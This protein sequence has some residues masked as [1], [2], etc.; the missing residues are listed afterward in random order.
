MIRDWAHKEE[1]KYGFD[2][3]NKYLKE[4]VFKMKPQHM[5]NMKKLRRYIKSS[6][7]SI[8]CFLMPHPGQDAVGKIGF[9]GS[10]SSLDEE[11]V[12][13]L[14]V[15]VPGI[16]SPE[17]L[18]L[19]KI[20]GVE[21]TGESLYWEILFYI[22]LL[23]S[24]KIPSAQSIYESTVSKFLQDLVSK[25]AK[26]YESTI[27]Q[28]VNKI[29]TSQELEI[30]HLNSKKRAMDNY[31]KEKKMGDEDFIT[32]YSNSLIDIIGDM[33]EQ[34]SKSLGLKIKNHMIQIELESARN[35]T[36]RQ[37]QQTEIAAKAHEIVE[38]R[39]QEVGKR[40]LEEN[41]EIEKKDLEISSLQELLRQH[42]NDL[43][44]MKKIY[45][46]RESEMRAQIEIER[47]KQNKAL[48][49]IQK[50]IEEN[51]L[52]L[53]TAREKEEQLKQ[54]ISIEN[55]NLKLIQ[56]QNA[57]Q[58]ENEL[59][60]LQAEAIQREI[61]NLQSELKRAHMEFAQKQ[62][63]LELQE[64]KLQEQQSAQSTLNSVVHIVGSVLSSLFFGIFG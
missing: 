12:N 61:N 58:K 28:E 11:F 64:K 46:Q 44:E 2:G 17:N 39:A 41:K 10:W 25:C 35:E 59:R 38:L 63:E 21:A 8:K 56:D 40:A 48:E 55:S 1:Y 26:I 62:I 50:Q 30:L 53:K 52:D 24:D 3:G 51:K 45:E 14:F 22:E 23:G 32:F 4:A 34:Q 6:Y 9:N 18:A 54:A 7:E 57:I 31:E 29:N 13:Q 60:L 37:I 47:E 43:T 16:L 49:E 5:E 36:A 27:N 42:Q 19:K 20:G 33:Y 15:L